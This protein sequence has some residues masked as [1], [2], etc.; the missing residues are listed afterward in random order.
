LPALPSGNISF[1]DGIPPTGTKL[2]TN[3]SANAS[4]LGPNSELNIMNEPVKRSLYFY[5]GLPE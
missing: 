2:W 4:K 3:I 1:L 5:F